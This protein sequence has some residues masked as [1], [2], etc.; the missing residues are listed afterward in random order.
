MGNLQGTHKN[1]KTNSHWSSYDGFSWTTNLKKQPIL[2]DQKSHS[3]WHNEKQKLSIPLRCI[4]DEATSQG[5][6]GIL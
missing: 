1:G 6:A 5:N 4:S 3:N 2:W